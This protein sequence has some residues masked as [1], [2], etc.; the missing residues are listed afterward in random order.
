MESVILTYYNQEQFYATFHLGVGLLSL[1][2]TVVVILFTKKSILLG[3]AY[4]TTIISFLLIALGGYLYYLIPSVRSDL[5]LTYLGTPNTF[6]EIEISRLTLIT[7]KYVYYYTL[8]V[9]VIILGVLLLGISYKYKGLVFGIGLS[10]LIYGM[11]LMSY[12]Y[13]A[14]Q[15]ALDYQKKIVD[16]SDA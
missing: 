5:Q 9:G 13:G 1:L 8:E 10:L 4:P 7:S 3:F 16:Y 12:D 11:F 6:Y 15:R 2:F 14:Q